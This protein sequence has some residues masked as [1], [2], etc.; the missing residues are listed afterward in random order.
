MIQIKNEKY[1]RLMLPCLCGSSAALD[2]S[3]NPGSLADDGSSIVCRVAVF[4]SHCHR[5]LATG[6]GGVPLHRYHYPEQDET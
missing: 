1:E 4:C 5:V 2:W 3:M 6:I